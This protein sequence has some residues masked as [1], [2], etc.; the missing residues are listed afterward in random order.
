MLAVTAGELSPIPTGLIYCSVI[1]ACQQLDE[2]RRAQE[3][4]AAMTRWCAQQ[5]DLMTFTGR[6]RV[7]R[8]EILQVRGAWREA[9]AE[10]RQAGDRRT[11]ARAVG[12]ALYR[13]GELHRL[14]GDFAAAEQAY[15]DASHHGLE[16]QPGLALLRLAQGRADA[17]AAAIGRVVGETH[18][19]LTRARLLPA[20]VQIALAIGDAAAARAACDELEQ[21]AAGRRS[22]LLAAIVAHARG[23]VA[24]DRGDARAALAA[25]REAEAAWQELDAPYETARVRV[26]VARACA[27]LGDDDSAALELDA[28]RAVFARL[29]AGPDLAVLG[30]TRGRARAVAARA[31]GAA[32]RGDRGDQQGDRGRAGAQRAD[33]RAAREQH[34]RQAAVST[35]A[36][37]TAFAYEHRLV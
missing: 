26:L 12:Q 36:A 35:R 2:L 1:D 23:A 33:R 14:Q 19:P 31:A 34:L 37:A 9:L 22:A 15:R 5:P 29:G 7:H 20:Q 13:Q 30:R 8:A 27:A 25:L 18:D 28:A 17:A 16:P 3:W 4:T 24:L 21:L 10:A 6:C 32:A 11:D